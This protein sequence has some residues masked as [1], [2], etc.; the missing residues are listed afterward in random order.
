MPF[1]LV[2]CD[3]Q[4]M[5]AAAAAVMM[6]SSI[7]C[8]IAVIKA[9]LGYAQEETYCVEGSTLGVGTACACCGHFLLP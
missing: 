2:K 9:V 4:L 6:L 5:S 3:N 8:F 7:H 1:C